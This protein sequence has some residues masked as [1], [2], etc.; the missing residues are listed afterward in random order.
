MG[1]ERE[2]TQRGMR[3]TFRMTWR[4][5]SNLSLI[6]GFRKCFGNC[7][8]VEEEPLFGSTRT[9][10]KRTGMKRR[11]KSR[12]RTYFVDSVTHPMQDARREVENPFDDYYQKLE[13]EHAPNRSMVYS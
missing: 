6:L 3:R 7:F 12:K 1:H 11:Y 4:R 5:L 10:Q 13:Q 9:K 2:Y 8:E